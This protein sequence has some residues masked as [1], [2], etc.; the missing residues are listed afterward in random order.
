MPLSHLLGTF[1][2]REVIR[3]RLETEGGDAVILGR[4]DAC[5]TVK[6][7]ALERNLACASSQLVI[8]HSTR[9]TERALCGAAQ[10]ER[11]LS[12]QR[13][14]TCEEGESE[15]EREIERERK[16][17]KGRWRKERES[18]DGMDMSFVNQVQ[19]QLL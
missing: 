18:E 4:A 15:G 7:M 17:E 16:R 10:G 8:Q 5:S 1:E 14:G 6:D 13:T 11:T 12:S 19:R 9:K 2:T 3:V